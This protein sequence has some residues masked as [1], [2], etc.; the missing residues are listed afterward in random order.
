MDKE[1]D[2]KTTGSIYPDATRG[3]FSDDH[4][5]Y[6]AT[7]KWAGGDPDKNNKTYFVLF[8][9]LMGILFI[10][11]VRSISGADFFF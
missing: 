4:S 9:I 11:A 3:S 10:F 1:E 7:K 2:N 5:N 8:I 6:G